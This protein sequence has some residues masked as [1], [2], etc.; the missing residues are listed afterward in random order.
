[1]KRVRRF[2]TVLERSMGKILPKGHTS[3]HPG[4]AGDRIGKKEMKMG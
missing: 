4:K 1:M 2:Q 3:G